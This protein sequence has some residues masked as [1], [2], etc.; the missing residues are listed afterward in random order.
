MGIIAFIVLG[1]LAGMIAKAIL[2]GAD[3]GGLIVTTGL[4]VLGALVGGFLAAALFDAHPLDD[5]FDLSTWVTAVAGRCSSC[6]STASSPDAGDTGSASASE[7]GAS[8]GMAA[9]R[10]L[11]VIQH[12]G[13]R[14]SAVGRYSL[15]TAPCAGRDAMTVDPGPSPPTDFVLN[16]HKVLGRLS[17][18]LTVV[19]SS[20]ANSLSP[21]PLVPPVVAEG[22][23]P[24]ALKDGVLR[25]LRPPPTSAKSS[26]SSG[27]FSIAPP[28]PFGLIAV[29]PRGGRN[30]RRFRRGRDRERREEMTLP[31]HPIRRPRSPSR[32]R[33]RIPLRPAAAAGRPAARADV[34]TRSRLRRPAR[35]VQPHGRAAFGL[36]AVRVLGDDRSGRI[37]RGHLDDIRLQAGRLDLG[38]RVRLGA[39][40]DARDAHELG[41][42]RDVESDARSLAAEC[43]PPGS[44]ATTWPSSTSAKTFTTFAVSPTA[45][46][47]SRA[48]VSL[49][50]TVFG[51]VTCSAP[52]ETNSCTV[53][54][55][56]AD[57]PAARGSAGRRCPRRRRW[58]RS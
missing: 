6:S 56:S 19:R 35:D 55:L 27:S 45:A 12:K 17:P 51:T 21:S 3:P 23:A 14:G 9:T 28:P 52:L 15:A 43:R 32:F 22:M 57:D 33:A 49:T 48:S 58:A 2:P 47:R 4:G 42:L 46:R 39:A 36:A 40:D 5:F 10:A 13:S 8:A 31:C 34:L 1:L 16:Q 7:P 38:G 24:G 50:P 11:V 29:P 30:R 44:C 20:S 26:P 18:L 53:E 25:R 54:P 37:G 41:S